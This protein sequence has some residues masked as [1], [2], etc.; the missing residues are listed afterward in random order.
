MAGSPAMSVPASPV[1]GWVVVLPVK[2]LEIAKTRLSTFAGALRPDLALA[3]AQDT[4]AAAL[5]SHAV[6]GLV[7][8]TDDERAAS[9][10]AALGAVV[11][12]DEPDAGINPALVHGAAVARTRWPGAGVAALSSDLPSLRAVEL[13]DALRLAGALA[14]AFV[15]DAEGTGSTLLAATDPGAF[16]PRFGHR[17]RAA[18]RAAGVTELDGPGLSSVRRDVDTAVD[19]HDALRL[20]LGPRSAALVDQLVRASLTGVQATVRTY[21]PQTRSG[22]VLLDDGAEIPYDAAAF[23]AGGLRL[24]RP[25]QRVRLDL[26]GDRVVRL[27]LH[28]FP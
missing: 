24:L 6:V 7:V 19:V 12:P 5:A 13:G 11:V 3:F 2:R 15:S 18:H 21:D 23:D 17:S 20:G 4:A 1:D 27:T 28:T 22:R 10:L 25:G 26:D 8:V 9:A 16:V 14:V